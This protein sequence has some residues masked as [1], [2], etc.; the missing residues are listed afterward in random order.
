[1]STS[2]KHTEDKKNVVTASRKTCLFAEVR[3]K[4][5]FLPSL[6]YEFVKTISDLPSEYDETAYLEFIEDWGTVS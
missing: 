4:D 1:M 6:Q 3:L 2:S 5:Y